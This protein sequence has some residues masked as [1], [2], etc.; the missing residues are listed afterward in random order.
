MALVAASLVQGALFGESERSSGQEARARSKT[1]AVGPAGQNGPIEIITQN[2]PADPEKPETIGSFRLVPFGY[3]DPIDEQKARRPCP[4]ASQGVTG[5]NEAIR[6]AFY[7]DDVYVPA[8]FES[9]TPEASVIC[10]GTV[11]ELRWQFAGSNA[12]TVEVVRGY[13]QLPF[14]IH[15]PTVDSWNTLEL[16]VAGGRDAIFLRRKPGASGPHALYFAD[17][18]LITIIIADLEDFDELIRIAESLK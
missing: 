7:Q 1:E 4:K 18:T 13:A 6:A 9:A 12:N 3:R 17:G 11:E 5:S 14:D 15:K 2:Y 10:D 16:G 8:G